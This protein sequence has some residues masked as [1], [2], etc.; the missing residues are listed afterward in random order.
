MTVDIEQVK[1]FINFL[2]EA[3]MINAIKNDEEYFQ[4]RAWFR[5]HMPNQYNVYEGACKGVIALEDADYVIKFDYYGS[6]SYCKLEADNYVEAVKA[7]LACYFAETHFICQIDGVTFTIQEKC[8]CDESAVCDSLG[9]YIRSI[10]NEINDQ[11]VW[12]AVEYL[13]EEGRAYE[14]FEDT[15]LTH[16]ICDHYIN[17]LHEGNFGFVKGRLV[18]TDFSGF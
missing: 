10:S 7:G 18:M 8:D 16:F 9:R 4:P 6:S 13:C 3:G 1:T 14:V 2:V 15:A 11:N 17:D 12:E 5:K